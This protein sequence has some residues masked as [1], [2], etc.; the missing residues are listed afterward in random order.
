MLYACAGALVLGATGAAPGLA[1]R[2]TASLPKLLGLSGRTD[3]L[4]VRPA[5]IIYTGDG[6][7]VLGGF[8]GTG[9]GGH[10]GHLHWSSWTANQAVG[11]GAVWLDN[12]TPN[13]ASG[14]FAPSAVTLRAFR[15]VGPIF[16]RL[17]LTYNYKGKHYVDHRTL[18]RQGSYWLYGIVSP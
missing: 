5:E 4:L 18:A 14:R 16:T 9:L 7:G 10:F 1:G 17:T 8:D 6:S 2:Q 12:C 13:C 11:G 3:K 15:P